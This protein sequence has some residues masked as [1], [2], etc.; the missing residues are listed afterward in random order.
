MNNK[1]VLAI[2]AASAISFLSGCTAYDRADSYL[3]K[4]VVSDVKKA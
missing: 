1:M 4:P 3:N 2:S